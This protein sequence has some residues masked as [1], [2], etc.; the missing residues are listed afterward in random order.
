M[1]ELWAIALGAVIV[2]DDRTTMIIRSFDGEHNLIG[3]IGGDTIEGLC[4]N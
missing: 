4:C 3:M 2:A 1:C